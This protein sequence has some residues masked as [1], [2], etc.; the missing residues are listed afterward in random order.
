M[1]RALDKVAF[2]PFALVIDK[3]RWS[4][5]AGE[6]SPSAYNAEWWKLREQY[7]GV[8]SPVARTEANF[9][10][11]AKFHIPANVPY[12]RYFLS[13]V[14]QFQLHKSLCEASGH[15]GP[16]HQCSIY[17]SKDAGQKLQKLLEM[18]STKPW[19]DALEQVTGTRQ[20]DASALLEYFAPLDSWLSKETSAMTCGW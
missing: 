14:L 15:E 4:V 8:K 1:K 19:P 2:L 12:L 18:G 7:Q 11:G 17:G 6:T 10:P 5:F 16:L 13:F 3:W 20:M 9:D